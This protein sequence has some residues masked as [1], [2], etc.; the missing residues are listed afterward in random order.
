MTI[1]H[2]PLSHVTKALQAL[3]PEL[4]VAVTGDVHLFHPKVPTR[5]IIHHLDHSFTDEL[6]MQLDVLLLNGDVFDRRLS[7][8]TETFFDVMT[9]INRLQRRCK[10]Y[11]VRLIVLEGTRSHDHRQSRFFS[12]LNEIGEIECDTIY[13]DQLAVAE[14]VPGYTALFIPDEVNRDASI[15][16]GQVRSLLQS[17]GIDQVDFSFMHGMFQYQVPIQSIAA[18]SLPFY[19][20]ITKHRIVINHVHIPSSKGIARAPGSLVRLKH[21]EEETKGFYIVALKDGVVHDWFVETENNV[22]FKT[23]M[24]EHLSLDETYGLLDSLD[25]LEK[26]SHIKLKLSRHSVIYPSLRQLKNDYPHFKI[27]EDFTDSSIQRLE[28]DDTLGV[29]QGAALNLTPDVLDAIIRERVGQ[30]LV[31]LGKSDLVPILHTLLLEP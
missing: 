25:S 14:L 28:S 19:E 27:T 12:Y 9:W 26:G 1:N 20:S 22:V 6:L 3:S 21:G 13:H 17:R 5:R 18:H 16:A 31:E 10:R 2:V 23:L 4:T 15:T 7:T 24:V 29:V 8:D 30:R 11:N